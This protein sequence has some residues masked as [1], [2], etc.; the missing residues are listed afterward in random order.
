MAAGIQSA[1]CGPEGTCEAVN[2]PYEL[3]EVIS[4]YQESP[5]LKA[6]IDTF[7][8]EGKKIITSIEDLS[9]ALAV[10]CLT[11]EAL[12]QVGRIVGQERIW[13]DPA[14]VPWFAFEGIPA[15][16][17]AGFDNGK[18]W[19]GVTTLVGNLIEADDTTHRMF[20]K[21]RMAKN[22][23]D[24][25]VNGMIDSLFLITCRTDIRIYTGN[26]L[27][28]TPFIFED[29]VTDGSTAGWSDGFS[30]VPEQQDQYR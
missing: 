22:N 24:G 17:R 21:A 15:A 19:D 20:I 30:L 29:G 11:G 25:T 7:V 8:D 26:G 6:Y 27:F 4:Q 10:D 5:N 12:D 14:I 18:L 28:F 3:H 23:F 9:L 16:N 13:Y 2:Y 1:G